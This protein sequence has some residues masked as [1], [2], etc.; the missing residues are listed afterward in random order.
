MSDPLLRLGILALAALLTFAI[1][2]GGRR[3]VARQQ[4]LALG[5]APL[6][7][8]TSTDG[9]VI[10]GRT[11]I[12]AFSSVGCTQCH[13]LQLPALRRLQEIR[14]TEIDV[15]E[16]DAAVSPELTKRYRIMTVPSTV[17]L[18]AEGEVHAVNYGFANLGKLRQQVDELL[19]QQPPV[20]ALS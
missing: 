6:T 12:L 1:I 20:T 17:V 5:A 18:N 2:W 15:V 10:Q 9:G 7:G 16:V 13:T 11:R 19:G 3:F 14:G 8:F 4:R